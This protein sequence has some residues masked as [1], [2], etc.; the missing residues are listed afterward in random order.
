MKINVLVFD[1]RSYAGSLS[2]EINGK[3]YEY[4]VCA[5]AAPDVINAINPPAGQYHLVKTTQSPNDPTHDYGQYMLF[6]ERTNSTDIINNHKDKFILVIHGGETDEDDKII[7]TE[8]GIRMRNDDLEDLVYVIKN[9][10]GAVS[11]TIESRHDSFIDRMLHCKVST[12]S[13]KSSASNSSYSR[14]TYKQSQS[15]DITDSPSFWLWVFNK[16][17]DND[18]NQSPPEVHEFPGFDGGSF[19]GGGSSG[20][21]SDQDNR[22]N[23]NQ[24]DTNVDQPLIID[25]FEN[26]NSAPDEQCDNVQTDNTAD[27][28]SDATNTAY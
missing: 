23:T 12:Q 5:Q 4:P 10:R 6:F 13:P 22:Q 20:S 27:F 15:F 19:G 14:D 1:S 7:P 24:L 8:G 9:Q 21:W 2:F 3:Y 25:P 28:E 18:N 17:S 16:I 26:N 11:M